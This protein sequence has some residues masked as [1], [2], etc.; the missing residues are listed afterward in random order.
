MASNQNDPLVTWDDIRVY[1]FKKISRIFFGFSLLGIF[2]IIYINFNEDKVEAQSQIE[3]KVTPLKT[4][5]ESESFCKK[6]K[7][8]EH[9]TGAVGLGTDFRKY[10]RSQF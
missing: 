1:Y 8:L 5:K 9:G 2:Y 4:K 3:I 10:C 7:T 6:M